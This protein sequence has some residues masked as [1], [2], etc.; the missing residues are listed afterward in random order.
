MHFVSCFLCR[1]G[2]VYSSSGWT[3]QSVF[4]ADCLT[5]PSGMMMWTFVATEVDDVF[6]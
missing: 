3:T 2:D 5:A 1:I 6:H 4:V